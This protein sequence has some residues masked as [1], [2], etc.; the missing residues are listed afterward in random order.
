VKLRIVIGIAVT[1][2]LQALLQHAADLLHPA[3]FIVADNDAL[4]RSIAATS[5][6]IFFI[7]V[8]VGSLI[9]KGRF[10]GAAIA[11]WSIYWA[12]TLVILAAIASPAVELTTIFQMA[13]FNWLGLTSTLL[14][15]IFGALLGKLLSRVLWP[16]SSLAAT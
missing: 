12:A 5:G 7:S 13:L 14:A 1:I 11:L 2:A 6:L 3:P 9:A 8:A 4:F 16:H 15:S 10:T